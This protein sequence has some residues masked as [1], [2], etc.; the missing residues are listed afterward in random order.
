MSSLR[1]LKILQL[2][3]EILARDWRKIISEKGAILQYINGIWIARENEAEFRQ[4]AVPVLN[5]LAGKWY[6]TSQKK[7]QISLPISN[8]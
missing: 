2:S 8:T 1:D 6:K 7:A 4:H 3:E 5:F